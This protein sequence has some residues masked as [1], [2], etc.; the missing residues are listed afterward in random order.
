MFYLDANVLIGA[1]EAGLGGPALARFILEPNDETHP[2]HSSEI[3]LSEVLVGPLRRADHDLLA[4]YRVLFGRE[5]IIRLVP[6][7]RGIL[8][9]AAE[10]RAGS[11][12][13]LPDAIHV[14]TA[15]TMG[16]GVILSQD[17]RLHVPSPAYQIDPFTDPITHSRRPG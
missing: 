16:C 2:L 14:A 4:R 8:E 13:R 3:T 9:R 10:L 15:L 17:K 7:T 1:L 5:D 6:V 12:M 11:A